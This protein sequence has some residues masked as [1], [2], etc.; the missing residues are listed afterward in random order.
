MIYLLINQ[1]PPTIP[2]LFIEILNN[3]SWLR[4]IYTDPFKGIVT[5]TGASVFLRL[6]QVAPPGLHLIILPFLDDMRYPEK[7]K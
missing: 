4:G 7:V 2:S 6:R 5:M 3:C 1:Q